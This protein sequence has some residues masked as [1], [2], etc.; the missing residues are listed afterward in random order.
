MHGVF[1]RPL[2]VG[3]RTC[4][5]RFAMPFGLPGTTLVD[6]ALQRNRR[7]PWQGGV[8]FDSRLMLL[9]SFVNSPK[10]A[11]QLLWQF[12]LSLLINE[13]QQLT[14]KNE[15]MKYRRLTS[16]IAGVLI[17]SRKSKGEW[18]VSLNRSPLESAALMGDE[19]RGGGGEARRRK[20]EKNQKCHTTH[21]RGKVPLLICR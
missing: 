11:L 16:A 9:P 6:K 5:A 1:F 10:M 3:R 4:S 19:G 8:I 17:S 14:W 18:V 12:L 13:K 2:L 20:K 7:R 15:T 21:F